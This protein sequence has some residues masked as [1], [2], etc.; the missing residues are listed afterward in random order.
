VGFLWCTA[1]A[2]LLGI[3]FSSLS[4]GLAMLFK[5]EEPLVVMGNFMTLPV[6]FLSSAFIPKEFLPGWISVVSMVNPV[7]YAVEAMQMAF[8]GQW[9]STYFVVPM[10]VLVVFTMVTF[11]WATWLFK[12]RSD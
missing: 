11:G 2:A 4:N 3:G 1:T 5:K 6:M 10:T 7:Q 9:Q 12:R 8:G